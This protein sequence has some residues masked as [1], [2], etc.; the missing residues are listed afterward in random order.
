VTTIDLF[1]HDRDTIDVPAG[2]VIFSEGEVGDLMYAV[3]E[4]KVAITVHGA[5][6]D[7]IETGGIIGE[8][9]LIDDSPR[10]AT[11]VALTDARL[12]RIDR[13]RF[14]DLVRNHPT[15][16]LR[17][18]QVMAARLRHTDELLG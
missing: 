11:A 10:S 15:F 4:G 14:T 3:V 8:L 9:A 2:A 16:A 5:S 12:A 6:V 18:M 17:V 1:R 13:Q 7:T